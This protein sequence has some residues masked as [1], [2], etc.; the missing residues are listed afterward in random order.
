MLNKILKRTRDQG[1]WVGE[2]ADPKKYLGFVYMISDTTA[3][4][5]YIGKKQYH[6]ARQGVAGCKSK[7]TD[8]RS[9]RWK[10]DCW[11][12]SNWKT[13][14]GSSPSLNKWMK[15]HPDHK[16]DY[17]IICQCYNKSELYYKEVEMIVL[18]GAIYLKKED[19][20]Y[21]YFNQS[22]PGV[23]FRVSERDHN[24]LPLFA[25]TYMRGEDI[26]FDNYKI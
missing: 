7:S 25:A 22:I 26:H 9:D 20:T 12:E 19:G 5:F 18:R 16:Y 15:E 17:I 1:H 10:E 11:K 24:E 23:K 14:K 2:T 4:R 3:G 21:L 13:Y 6:L 8:R